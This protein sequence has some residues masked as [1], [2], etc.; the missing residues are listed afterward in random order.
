MPQLDPSIYPN[1][2][3][4]LVLSLVALYLILTR[5]AVPRIGNVLLERNEAVS[6]DLEQAAALKRRAEEAET[7]Y[8]AA[9]ARAREESGKIAAE[10]KAQIG[11]ELATLMAKADA[12]IAARS[13]ESIKRIAEI[14]ESAARSISQVAHEVAPAIV[15]A[16]LPA[17]G[18]AQ[19]VDAAVD[20]RL[21]G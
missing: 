8:N 20:A 9:L 10:T 15:A 12:E 11:K 1:L 5:I 7:S 14:Q 2:I 17:A 16:L 19:A 13:A 18:D 3:F 4:W 21:E 6:N